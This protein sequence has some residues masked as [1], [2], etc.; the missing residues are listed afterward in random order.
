[1]PLNQTQRPKFYEE[2]YLGAADLTAAVDYGRIQSARHALGAHTWGIAAGL[3]L[4]EKEAPT[5]G[6]QVEMFIQPGYAWDGFGRP[7]VVL[8]SYKIPAELFKSIPFA[9][10]SPAGQLIKVWLCYNES[11]TQRARPDFKIGR[12]HV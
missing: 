7:I 8:A 9:A 3:Q 5:G 12:A 11:A 4:K 6:G 2:Q 10:G 1:M